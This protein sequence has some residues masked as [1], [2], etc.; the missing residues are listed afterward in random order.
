M[1]TEAHELIDIA[2]MIRIMNVIPGIKTSVE[3]RE[4]KA[5]D[6][7]C[8]NDI[9][10]EG[11]IYLHPYL[12]TKRVIGRDQHE[13]RYAITHEEVIPGVRYYADMSGEPDTVDFVEVADNLTLDEALKKAWELV[14]DNLINHA[15]EA[16]YCEEMFQEE[17]GIQEPETPEQA[18]QA[19]LQQDVLFH[20]RQYQLATK[21]L[22]KDY[23]VLFSV[24][25]ETFHNTDE[26]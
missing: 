1:A 7:Q 18:K 25:D 13:V 9:V 6:D 8:Y 22:A 3:V 21:E 5:D 15:K 23:N 19:S 26:T 12:K 24:M 14:L 2:H 17:H 10:I 16:D 11:W 20:W 4:D